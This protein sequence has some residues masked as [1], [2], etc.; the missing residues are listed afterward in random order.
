MTD[1]KKEWDLGVVLALIAV[2]ISI[3]TMIISLV[4]TSIMKKQQQSMT[5]S[6]KASVWPYITTLMTTGM[7]NGEIQFKVVLEN[8]GVGPALMNK[9]EL[10]YDDNSIEK[11]LIDVI[12]IHCPDAIV[13]NFNTNNTQE[14]VLSPGETKLIASVKLKEADF[15]NFAQFTEKVNTNYCYS[16]I[17]GDKWMSVDGKPKATKICK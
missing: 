8:K 3:C 14:M 15:I 4:E 10:L 5:E 11:S 7:E 16:N 13:T 2:M 9:M 6:A 1:K 12:R 17:Y